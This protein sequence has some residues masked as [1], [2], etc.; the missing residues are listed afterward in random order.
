MDLELVE[1]T[2]RHVLPQDI[3]AAP[4]ADVLLSGGRLGLLERNLEPV[5]HEPVGRA[6]LHRQRLPYRAVWPDSFALVVRAEDPGPSCARRS[7]GRPSAVAYTSERNA[8]A[9]VMIRWAVATSRPH[10]HR[11]RPQH[12]VKAA[13][14]DTPEVTT[15]GPAQLG[16]HFVTRDAARA[17]VAQQRPGGR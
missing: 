7:P 10:S 2:G 5:G 14:C 4:A 6:A 17:R 12:P 15:H 16:Q 13:G 3:G 1:E 9:A 8:R 11:Q